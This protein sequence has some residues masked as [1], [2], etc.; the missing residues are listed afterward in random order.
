SKIAKKYNTSVNDLVRK[1]KLENPN[2]IR[3]GQLIVL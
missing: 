1:N 3:V 2:L